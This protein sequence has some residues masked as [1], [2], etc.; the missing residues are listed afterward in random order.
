[1]NLKNLKGK[2]VC[3]NWMDASGEM[4]ESKKL[5]DET[6]PGDLL[7]PT[8]T[9]GILYKYDNVAVVI[10]SEDSDDQVDF[11]TIPID[12][13]SNIRELKETGGKK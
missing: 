2:I 9:Y 11:T 4:K 13:I 6:S 1:M 5:L 3:A 12:W 8:N 10:V 7:V